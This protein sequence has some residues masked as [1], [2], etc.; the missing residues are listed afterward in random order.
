[1]FKNFFTKYFGDDEEDEKLVDPVVEQRRNERFSSPL[2]YDEEFEKTKEEKIAKVEKVEK[3]KKQELKNKD[4]V[5]VKPKNESVP[6]KMSR[7]ISPMYGATSEEVETVVRPVISRNAPQ[8]KNDG[9]V[10][11]I[12]PFYGLRNGKDEKTIPIEEDVFIE[13]IDVNKIEEKVEEKVDEKLETQKS[14]EDNLRNIAKII[15]EEQ[16]Q[17]RIIE[18]RTGEFKL[19]FSNTSPTTKE[20][21]IDKIEDNMSLDE[22]MSLYEKKFTD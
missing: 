1:M 19:D 7:V 10:P 12:S 13:K 21:L 5:N 14:V 16:D 6:Y 9:I 8:K 15:E 18:E 11:V 4:D 17:L 20:S 2:I 22:L 3:T